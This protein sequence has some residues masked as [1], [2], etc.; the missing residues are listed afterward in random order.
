MWASTGLRCC[1]YKPRACKGRY[2]PAIRQPLLG[3]EL[4]H[5]ERTIPRAYRSL[6]RYCENSRPSL[7]NPILQLSK[8]IV[9]IAP[10]VKVAYPFILDVQVYPAQ[11]IN[12]FVILV[13]IRF[14]RSLFCHFSCHVDRACFISGGGSLTCVGHSKA[15]CSIVRA[16]HFVTDPRM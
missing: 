6:H 13:S 14:D 2:P 15:S 12:L 11:I 5:P 9:I 1:A 4:A 8:V 7:L 3:R 10:P 16:C